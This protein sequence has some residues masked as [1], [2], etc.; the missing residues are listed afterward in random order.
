M[1]LNIAAAAFIVGALSLFG[2]AGISSATTEQQKHVAEALMHAQAA[3]DAGQKGT[4]N[5]VGQHAY[6]ALE[7]A[8]Q[9]ED[10][11]PDA[12][13]KPDPHITEAEAHLSQAID[14]AATGHAD[15]ATKHVQEA[16]RHLQVA[17]QETG[18]K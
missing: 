13:I 10:V 14:H 6:Q 3:V 1:K 2:A 18:G 17:Y 15:I 11:K 5:A 12:N 8:K 16:I 7:R 9:A 4:A